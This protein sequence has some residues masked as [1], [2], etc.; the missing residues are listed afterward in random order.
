MESF[1]AVS[2]SAKPAGEDSVDT[3][4]FVNARLAS[5]ETLQ[6]KVTDFTAN[7]NKIIQNKNGF[8]WQYCM[9][10]KRQFPVNVALRDNTQENLKD[11]LHIP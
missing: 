2:S 9:S 8:R 7:L 1:H 4:K 6:S 11:I 5:A 10:N 3:Q